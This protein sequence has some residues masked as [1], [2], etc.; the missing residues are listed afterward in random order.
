MP[1]AAA[2]SV[3]LFCTPWGTCPFCYIDY[4]S[5]DPGFYVRG[6]GVAHVLLGEGSEAP[7]N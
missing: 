4:A 7:G 2:P 6:E 3:S 5:A 1:G